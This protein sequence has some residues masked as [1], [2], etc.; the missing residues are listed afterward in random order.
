MPGELVKQLEIVVRS[1]GGRRAGAGRP[2]RPG[3][4]T[5]PHRSRPHHDHRHPVHV[6]LR[7]TRGLPS[8]RQSTTSPALRSALAAA[9]SGTFRVLHFSIQADHVHLLVE[10]DAPTTIS[11]GV[12]GLAIRA[13]KA[14]NRVLGRRGRVWG[15]RFHA[16]ALQTPR[17][18]RNALVYVINNWAKH[19]PGARGLDPQSSAAWFT[20]WKGALPSAGRSLV[21]MPRTWLARVG[22]LRHGRVSIDEAPRVTNER[23]TQLRRARS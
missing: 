8:L 23:P 14:V 9:S 12:Q 17:E 1:W 3:R 15:D 11:R 7:A 6:T 13:A 22:W 5:V 21:A 18:M 2:R 4:G 10:A 16:R 20:G 19:I